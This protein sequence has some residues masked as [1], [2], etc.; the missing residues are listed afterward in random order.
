MSTVQS[1]PSSHRRPHGAPWQR[2]RRDGDGT[3]VA[4]LDLGTNNCRLLIARPAAAGFRVVDG[5]SRIVRLGEGL[6][7]SGTLSPDAMDRAL[8]ALQ[9]CAAK[10]RHRGVD[11]ARYVGTE[12]CRRATNGGMF[13]DRVEDETGL[14][15]EIITSREEAELTLAG[16]MPL[17]DPAIPHVLLFDVGGGSA[18]VLWVRLANDA[19]PVVLGWT[20]LPCG[21]INLT[22]RHGGAEFSAAAYDG[23]V[24]EVAEMLRP[25]EE[26]HRI[27][28]AIAAGTMQ[29]IGTAGT[30][31]TIAGVH[32]GLQRYNRSVVDGC[33]LDFD[34]VRTV[35]RMLVGSSFAERA[36]HGCIGTG[37]AELVVAG[38]AVLEA[39]CLTW[40][41]GR[42]RVADRGVREGILVA[43]ADQVNGE[44]RTPRVQ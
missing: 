6:E 40:P 21:V 26:K 3:L 17:L 2:R 12:A 9:V 42:L 37:R 38:C 1:K 5:F 43:L 19:P 34:A 22:E 30:V 15:L 18:E 31:T 35:S 8:D 36:A 11:R 29:M 14:R 33:W 28:D 44:R 39:V 32:M 27:S 41:A 4:A 13:L 20:S 25:F 16:C 10:L 24:R 23:V 7:A